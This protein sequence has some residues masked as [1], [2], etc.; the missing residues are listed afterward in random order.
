MLA[1]RI[2]QFGSPA[3]LQLEDLPKPNL[4]DGE[5]LVQIQAAGIMPGDVKNVA[6]N[7]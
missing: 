3:S 4:A 1:A 6:G 5:V 7:I 2:N